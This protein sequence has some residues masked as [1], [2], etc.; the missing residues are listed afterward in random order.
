MMFPIR[1]DLTCVPLVYLSSSFAQLSSS[2]TF[3]ASE[4]DY[5]YQCSALG[6]SQTIQR[7]VIIYLY[8]VPET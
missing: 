2:A 5:P 7:P 4:L 1:K 3:H 6:H 8:L